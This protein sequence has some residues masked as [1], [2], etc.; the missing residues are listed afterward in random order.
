MNKETVLMKRLSGLCVLLLMVVSLVHAADSKSDEAA[1]RAL[2]LSNQGKST[3][4]AVF[5][6][7]ALKRPIIG[8]QKGDEFPGHEL[9]KR[10]NMKFQ[11][12][13]QRIDVAASGDLAYEFSFETLEFD[14]AG[15]PPKHIAFKTGLLRVWKKVNGEWRIAALFVRPL[16]TPFSDSA[17]TASK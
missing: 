8:H 16:D 17:E 12:D 11:P 10:S 13:I 4:D 1:I 14:Q 2:I 3:D 6:N 5:W 7:G 9:S 15:T